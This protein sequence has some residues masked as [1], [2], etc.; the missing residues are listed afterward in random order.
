MT[1]TNIPLQKIISGGQTGVDRAALDCAI[2]LKIAHGG[3]CPKNR[4][5]EDGVI[6]LHY[7]LQETASRDYAERTWRNVHDAD[8]TLIILQKLPPIGGT[9]L[10]IKI[11][12]QLKKPYL[13]FNCA[14][15][16]SPSAITSWII[17]NRIQI[18]NAAGPRESQN[19]GIY[20]L[21]YAILQAVIPTL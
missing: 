17:K 6:P 3:W 2:A 7:Q 20:H 13:I 9:L 18:L 21:A 5:A 12:K 19:P 16:S 10:T 11:A 8:G 4:R 1:K 15:Q 14:Q